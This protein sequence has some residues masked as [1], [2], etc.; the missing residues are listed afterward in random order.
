MLL[1]FFLGAGHLLLQAR[2]NHHLAHNLAVAWHQVVPLDTWRFY[3]LAQHD[4]SFVVVFTYLDV[5]IPMHASPK[6][7]IDLLWRLLRHYKSCCACNGEVTVDI[8]QILLSA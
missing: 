5:H 3:G 6:C 7:H 4:G 1:Y 8:H 2:V